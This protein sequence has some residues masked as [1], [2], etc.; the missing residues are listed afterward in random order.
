IKIFHGDIYVKSPGSDRFTL[1]R[2]PL[3]HQTAM[4]IAVYDDRYRPR[5]LEDHPE[6]RRWRSE[7]GWTVDD[8]SSHRYQGEGKAQDQWSELRHHHLVP[9][10]EQ[11]D[12]PLSQNPLPHPPRATL[13]TDFYAYNTNMGVRTSDLITDPPMAPDGAWM[14]PHWV[15]DLTVA[16][17]LEIKDVAAEGSVRLELVKAGV[18]HRCTIELQTGRASF[19]RGAEV[20][21]HRDTPMKGPGR[22]QVEFANVD[23]RLMLVINGRAVE[24]E[25]FVYETGEAIP[26]PAAADLAPAAVAVRNAAVV[27]S[28]LVLKRDIY[29]TQDPGWI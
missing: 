22:F 11:W 18:P 24:P 27:A 28:D 29:Y 12:A 15:G 21:G 17:H 26:I 14:Q 6:W 5:A 16:T 10:P 3:R 23:D 1:A 19:T 4:Q 8:S 2:K 7:S 25:G 9:D 20:L 13:I